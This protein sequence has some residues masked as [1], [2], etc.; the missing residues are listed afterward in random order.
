M[1]FVVCLAG[2]AP[3]LFNHAHAIHRRNLLERLD[4]A[5]VQVLIGVEH[6]VGVLASGLVGHAL[7]IGVVLGENGRDLA[8]HVGHVGMQAGNTACGAR[9]AHA[10]GGVVDAVRDVAVFQVILELADGHVGAVG[11]GLAGAGARMRG[12]KRIG[13]LDGLGRGKVAAKPAELALAQGGV[14]GVFVNDGLARVVDEHAS[15]LICSVL[16]I[17]MVS[18]L[19]GT[20]TVR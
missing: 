7:H 10:A 20:C 18:A 4:R 16:I 6:G 1:G 12:D 13:H 5:A 11:L 9:L 15:R 14:D 17:P 3:A 2:L 19:L 8:D